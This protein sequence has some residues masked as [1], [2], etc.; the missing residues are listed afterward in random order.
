MT[1]IEFRSRIATERFPSDVACEVDMQTWN[2]R[3]WVPLSRNWSG[4]WRPREHFVMTHDQLSI[5]AKARRNWEVAEVS[6]HDLQRDGLRV[7]SSHPWNCVVRSRGKLRWLALRSRS[8]QYPA[9]LPNITLWHLHEGLRR[10]D[11]RLGHQ[12]PMRCSQ[13]YSTSTSHLSTRHVA[14]PGKPTNTEPVKLSSET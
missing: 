2:G 4:V 9:C 6:L 8:L 13:P 14:T 7:A 12:E 3:G 10:Q 5:C 1:R 11:S